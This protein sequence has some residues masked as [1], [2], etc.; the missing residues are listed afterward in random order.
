M[1]DAFKALVS[2]PISTIL[3][4]L[5]FLAL[6]VA[7]FG[8]IPGKSWEDRLGDVERML[9]GLMG[10]VLMVAGLV[11]YASPHRP[12][13]IEDYV[14]PAIICL[15]GVLLGVELVYLRR[16]EDRLV[17]R[18]E[19]ATR[20]ILTGFAEVF[21]CALTMM[22]NCRGEMYFV[23]FTLNFGEV[24]KQNTDLTA[25]YAE[26][27]D[28]KRTFE[29]DVGE[30]SKLFLQRIDDVR[31]IRI[32]TTSDQGTVDN[33]L[34][35]LQTK[36]K[37]LDIEDANDSVKQ[38]KEEVKKRA[39]GRIKV[40]Q[41]RSHQFEMWESPRLPLQLFIAGMP[42][43]KVGCL[44]F[45]VGTENTAEGKVEGFYTEMESLVNVFKDLALGLMRTANGA[46]RVSKVP[47]EAAANAAAA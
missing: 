12:R 8:K 20:R 13:V 29:Q 32:L 10:F 41:G 24:H 33:F 11:I 7:L 21:D 36:Y 4:F 27:T 15:F 23:N 18:V 16:A 46:V 31:C 28:H 43:N 39:E 22:R 34:T 45:L 44:V 25:T 1:V 37:G 19:D 35:R 30:F 14:A 40:L 3:V 42:E 47:A 5:G 38:A 9:A 6:V 2:S 17:S 26:M